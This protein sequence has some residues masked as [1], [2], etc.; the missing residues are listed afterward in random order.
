VERKKETVTVSALMLQMA[1]L[2]AIGKT[3]VSAIF[4]QFGCCFGLFDIAG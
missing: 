4:R 3:L 1:T 2:K